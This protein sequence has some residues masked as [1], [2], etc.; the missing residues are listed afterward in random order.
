MAKKS[1]AAALAGANADGDDA[2]AKVK[3]VKMWCS[4]RGV[5]VVGQEAELPA[6]IAEALA[7][8]GMVELEE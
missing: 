2:P 3:F 7:D 8:E 6:S 4:A 5:F 1:Q